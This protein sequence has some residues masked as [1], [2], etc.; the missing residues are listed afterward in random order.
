MW[1][2]HNESSYRKVVNDPIHGHI[3]LD[4]QQLQFI[5]TPQF[6]RLRELHQLGSSYF[7]FL[8]A[9]HRRFE[10]SIGS[11]FKEAFIGLGVSYLAQKLVS[12]LQ[13][14]QPEL[15]ISPRDASCVKIAGLC[16]DL[17]SFSLN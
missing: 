6:Q 17:G 14:V 16:H 3:Q 4:S 12:H 9:S 2:E 10:H 7:V 11:L 8:G 1:F 5:D 13:E 15:E